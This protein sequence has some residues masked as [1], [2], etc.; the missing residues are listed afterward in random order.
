MADRISPERRSANMA[1]IRSKNTG[2]EMRVR[3]LAYRLGY[4]FRLHFKNLPGKPDLVFV[5]RRKVIFVH[6]C[7]W[8][9]H[10]GCVDCSRPNSR[11][12]YWLPKLEAT[13]KRDSDSL[14]KL[15]NAGWQSLVIWDCETQ[16]EQRL[17]TMIMEF[18]GCPAIG[19][20]AYNPNPN[21]PAA[22]KAGQIRKA[23]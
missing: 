22:S 7:F 21:L 17:A 8:H 6:G 19:R 11:R 1:R 23:C 18:L 13:K 3:K 10:A 15:Q 4:R 20:G 16:D 14:L 5:G 12:D 9:Q 2:P